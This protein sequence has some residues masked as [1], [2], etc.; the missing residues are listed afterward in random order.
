MATSPTAIRRA[1]SSRVRYSVSARVRRVVRAVLREV[2]PVPVVLSVLCEQDQRRGVRGLQ[3][4]HQGE[5]LEGVRVEMRHP[6][7]DV[8]Q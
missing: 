2:G 7:Q 3:R 8:R 6:W 4:Q 1:A 5:E